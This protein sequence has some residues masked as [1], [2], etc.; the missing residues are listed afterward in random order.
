MPTSTATLTHSIPHPLAQGSYFSSWTD[1]LGNGFQQA[2]AAVTTVQKG[3]G[4]AAVQTVQAGKTAFSWLYAAASTVGAVATIFQAE[5][6]RYQITPKI[7]ADQAIESGTAALT[8]ALT[9]T[10]HLGLK[11]LQLLSDKAG[12]IGSAALAELQVQAPVVGQALLSSA[13]DLAGKAAVV[14]QHGLVLLGDKAVEV[15]SAAWAELQVQA[16]VVGKALLSGAQDSLDLLTGKVIDITLPLDIH[17]DPND[18]LELSDLSAATMQHDVLPTQAPSPLTSA[19][20]ADDGNDG[21]D[22]LAPDGHGLSSS[23]YYSA[24]EYVGLDCSAAWSMLP[25]VEM[26]ISSAMSFS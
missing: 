2:S 23:L 3:L 6:E 1:Y 26:S 18:G 25:P 20:A 8:Q 5:A 7:L 13:Q 4:T 22:E 21:V 11:A 24:T 10:A 19:S 16:P 14:A 12:E 17:F 15:G 9:H